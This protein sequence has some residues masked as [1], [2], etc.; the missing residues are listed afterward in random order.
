MLRILTILFVVSFGLVLFAGGRS[1]LP[2]LIADDEETEERKEKE[3]MKF[4]H[5]ISPLISYYYSDSEPDEFALNNLWGEFTARFEGASGVLLLDFTDEEPL[6][7][8]YAEIPFVLREEWRD[9]FNLRFGLIEV[10][11]GYTQRLFLYDLRLPYPQI[12]TTLFDDALGFYDLGASL[13][14]KVKTRTA[15]IFYEVA[16]L[17]GEY[18]TQWEDTT[19]HKSVAASLSI[20]PYRDCF[21]G[22]SVYDGDR[23]DT[24]TGETAERYRLG[25]YAAIRYQGFSF[26]GEYIHGDDST[27]T[28]EELQTDGAFVEAGYYLWKHPKLWD[29]ELSR[30]YGVQLIFRWDMLDPPKEQAMRIYTRHTHRKKLIYTVAL[31]IDIDSWV[32]LTIYYSKLDFGRYWSGYYFGVE[33]NDDR[34]GVMLSLLF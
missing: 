12:L 11:F 5:R 16:L 7:K 21:F 22:V 19:S 33:D 15:S 3:G 34:A 8:A 13:S 17:N 2:S 9:F 24:T 14:G 28:D 6:R 20:S 18:A 29:A 23:K 25:A 1:L 4:T 10:P 27:D 31:A 32:R 30:Y 26:I